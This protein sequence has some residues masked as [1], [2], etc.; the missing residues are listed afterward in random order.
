MVKFTETDAKLFLK[1]AKIDISKEKF[2]IKDLVKG[3]RVEQEHGKINRRTNVTNDDLVMTGKIALAH[4]YEDYTYY[5]KLERCVEKPSKR[6]QSRAK[7]KK[8]SRKYSK[9]KSIN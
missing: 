5:E 4:L 3:M 2:T 7:S 1:K 6:K 9:K 8:R